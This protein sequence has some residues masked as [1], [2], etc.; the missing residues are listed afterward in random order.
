MGEPRDNIGCGFEPR[1]KVGCTGGVVASVVPPRIDRAEFCAGLC[2]VCKS[3]GITCR[4]KT[5]APTGPVAR[6][7]EAAAVTGA[8]AESGSCPTDVPRQSCLPV[9]MLALYRLTPQG[10]AGQSGGEDCR[11]RADCSWKSGL[12]RVRTSD[13]TGCPAGAIVIDVTIT[14]EGAASGERLRLRTFIVLLSDGLADKKICFVNDS[15]GSAAGIWIWSS[16]DWPA[17]GSSDGSIDDARIGSGAAAASAA[18]VARADGFASVAGIFRG[19]GVVSGGCGDTCAVTD[20]VAFTSL[21][22]GTF[23]AG[24]SIVCDSTSRSGDNTSVVVD[25]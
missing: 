5:E 3:G 6:M 14:C 16:C 4:G 19:A 23:A 18:G 24:A 7:L 13:E 9:S 25:T 2:G 21:S 22:S 8:G 20:A 17:A 15:A 12:L 1:P 10:C 11:R